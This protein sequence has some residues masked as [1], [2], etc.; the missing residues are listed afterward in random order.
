MRD[1][2]RCHGSGQ[3]RIP[4]EPYAPYDICPDCEELS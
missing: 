4:G 2:E 3:I 1:C